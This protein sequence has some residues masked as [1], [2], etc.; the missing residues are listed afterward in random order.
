MSFLNSHTDLK[1]RTKQFALAIIEL[2][3]N[4]NQ[5]L[6]E[7]EITKQL[8]KS[9]ITVGANTRSAFGGNSLKEYK[10]NLSL[11]IKEA[12]KCTYWI[13]LLIESNSIQFKCRFDIKQA[14]SN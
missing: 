5:N 6:A 9:G 13:D 11:V 10:A 12:D 1:D 2:I 4:L 14:T 8:I 3:K 7:K